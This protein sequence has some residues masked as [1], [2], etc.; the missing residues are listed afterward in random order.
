M[1]NQHGKNSAMLF[2]SSK[3][4]SEHGFLTLPTI[5][6][7]KPLYIAFIALTKDFHQIILGRLLYSHLMIGS[8][9]K[10]YGLIFHDDFKAF[11]H[12]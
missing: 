9:Q 5:G 8:P 1:L 3:F 7:E 6:Q 11:F 2:S 12:V 4:Y 10:L